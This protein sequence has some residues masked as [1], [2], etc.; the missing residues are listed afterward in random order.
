MLLESLFKHLTNI[1]RSIK[2]QKTIKK[3]QTVINWTES[4]YLKK[5]EKKTLVWPLGYW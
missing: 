4:N 3:N 5:I 2:N 1:L